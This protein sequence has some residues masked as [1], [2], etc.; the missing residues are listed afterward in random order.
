MFEGSIHRVL[1]AICW[2]SNQN[3]R[4]RRC[5]AA[6]LLIAPL[7][8][9]SKRLK[10]AADSMKMPQAPH[11]SAAADRS[12]VIAR[13]TKRRPRRD[14]GGPFSSLIEL[15]APVR[16]TRSFGARKSA[17]GVYSR[18]WTSASLRSQQ[19]GGRCGS[20]FR[21][22]ACAPKLRLTETFS[23]FSRRLCQYKSTNCRHLHSMYDITAV[24]QSKNEKI[25]SFISIYCILFHSFVQ[26]CLKY[27]QNTVQTFPPVEFW[28]P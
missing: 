15:F 2:T 22:R 17:R 16:E 25:R 10:A 12:R 8:G 23:R 3:Q 6:A 1:G 18:T 28:E 11:A 13:A 5:C 27:L 20:R 21:A 26:K 19:A 9:F 7:V 4:R 14:D 24:C